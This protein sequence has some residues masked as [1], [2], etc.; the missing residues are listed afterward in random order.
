MKEG[1]RVK[2]WIN[3]IYTP[4]VGEE[5]TIE[6]IDDIGTVH[7]KF[8]SGKTLGAVEDVDRIEKLT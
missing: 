1:D 6:W 2:A 7:I 5:G 3:D 8:D 4:I